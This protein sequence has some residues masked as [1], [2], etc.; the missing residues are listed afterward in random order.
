MR[1]IMETPEIVRIKKVVQE[2]PAM[3]TIYLDTKRETLPGQFYMIWLPGADEKPFSA[4]SAD[5]LAFTVRKI[6][7]FTS[8]LFELKPGERIGLRGPYGKGYS[9]KENAVIIGGGC[10]TASIAMLAEKIKATVIIGAKTKD[11]LLF[12]ERLAKNAKKLIV[13]TDDGSKGKK[14][15]V[16]EALKEA[17]EKEKI[18]QIY[19]C[20]PEVMMVKCLAIA[21]E[22]KI[23]IELG[24]ERYMKC[25]IGI[26]GSCA[27]GAKRI[28]KEGPVFTGEELKDTEFGKMKLDKS[29]AEIPLGGNCEPKRI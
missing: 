23:P 22:K 7:L 25:G 2:N 1:E 10:G 26:C 27:L 6:G 4:T 20:G 28:C 29:G 19:A 13:M 15:F 12:E 11:E 24:L 5:P 16:T 9:E 14:G 3:K 21:N 8:K 18:K 17:L